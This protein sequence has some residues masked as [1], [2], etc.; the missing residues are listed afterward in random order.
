MSTPLQIKI[1][2]K[3]QLVLSEE[4]DGKVELGRQSEVRENLYSKRNE[5]DRWRLVIAAL[6][7]DA[8]SRKHALLEPL[9]GKSIRLTN[10]SSV[11]PLRVPGMDDIPPKGTREL[12][13]PTMLAIGRKT[14]RVQAAETED[15]ALQ[16]LEEATVA[17]GRFAV[18]PRLSA[19]EL[20][21]GGVEVESLVRWLQ[22]VIGVLHTAASSTDFFQRAAQS[23]VE[24]IGLDTGRIL[25]Q[26]EDSWQVEAQFAEPNSPREPNWRPSRQVLKRLSQEKRTFWHEADHSGLVVESASM[27]GVSSIVAAPIL[28]RQGDVIGALYGEKRLDGR[29]SGN[30]IRK[31]DAMLLDLMAS[32]VAAG[33]ARLEQEQAALAARVQFEQFFTPELASELSARPDL[34]KGRNVEVSMLFCDIRGFSRVSERLGPARTVDWIGDVMSVFS[35]CVI[36]QQGVLVDYIGDE[37]IAM[38]GA[39]KEAPDHARLA[40]RAALAMIAKLPEINARWRSTLGEEMAVG[41]GVNSGLAQVGNTGSNRKFKYGALGNTVNLASR[42]QGATKYLK[43]AVMITGSTQAQLDASFLT[44]RLCKVEVVNIAE[45]VDLYELATPGQMDWTQFRASYE[46]ALSEFEAQEF[47]KAARTL[48]NLLVLHPDDGPSLLLLS[49]A[50]SCLVEEPET[51]DAVWRLPGK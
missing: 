49:R 45:P 13:I 14:I 4:F 17:P 36:E 34:L 51:F 28:N 9:D 21:T 7:E 35:D 2:D 15:L 3:S 11:I 23:I 29:A 10:T 44:R 43:T 40:C 46:S 12:S 25:S 48:S 5:G 1:Y 33:L 16:G 20:P 22:G 32:G 31:L 27:V 18:A 50:V 6:D 8:V 47:H 37:L 42:V 41:I 38:W 26:K 39:P 24:I 19:L 30:R